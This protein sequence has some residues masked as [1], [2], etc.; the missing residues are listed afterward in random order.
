[1]EMSQA[2]QPDPTSSAAVTT[3]SAGAPATVT[4][5]ARSA[6]PLPV[7]VARDRACA[8]AGEPAKR[9]TD[10]CDCGLTE[11]PPYCDG[12]CGN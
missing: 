10:I 11:D 6:R 8:A 7:L 4:G 12:T 3:G 2:S 9:R 1:M 5:L